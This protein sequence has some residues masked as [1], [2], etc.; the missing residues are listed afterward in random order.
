[1]TVRDRVLQ[2][3]QHEELNFWL[4]NR[5][6]PRRPLSR[7]A[8]WFTRIEHPLVCG[9]S[10][11]IWRF[12]S[13]L[14][15]R[16]AQN[17][18]F[19]S[20]HD[21]FTRRLKAGAR[22]IDS[23]PRTLVSPCDGIVGACGTIAGTHLHQIK[24][25]SYCLSEL[26]RDSRLAD[27]YRN[28]RYV[29]LRLTASMYHR[30]HAPHDCRIEHL[31]YVP[32]DSWNVNPPALRR[33]DALYCKNERAVLRTRLS[34]GHLITLVP[35]G[36]V[37][38]CG[39]RLH[40]ADVEQ[41]RRSGRNNMPCQADVRKGEEMGWFEHGSTIVVL[42]PEDFSLCAGVEEGGRIRVG[43]ALMRLP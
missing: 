20:L 15:L 12:F 31:S 36:A 7:F 32:G 29:T 2:T 40:F 37:L 10:I 13:D 27:V 26:L 6:F 21:C 17:A 30:F 38:V 8:G 25:K 42:A 34:C 16:E 18:R 4:T 43:E 33:I 39:I 35:V 9:P 23:D 11:A 24:G 22:P 1:M 19:R 5:I 41:M 3:L 28:G 14:D